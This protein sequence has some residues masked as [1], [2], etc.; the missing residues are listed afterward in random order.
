[1]TYQQA[2]QDKIGRAKLTIKEAIAGRQISCRLTYEAGELGIDDSGSL[3]VLFRIVSDVASLQAKNPRGKNF[4]QAS[5]SNHKVKI[6]LSTSSHAGVYEKIGVRPWTKGLVLNFGNHY[7]EKGDL[8]HIDF[9]NWRMQTF[10]EKT[11]EFRVMID[12]FATA[13]YLKLPNPPETKILPDKPQKLT[14]ITPTKIRVGERFKFL[15]KLEDQW[16]NPCTQK[17]GVFKLQTPAGLDCPSEVNFENGRAEVKVKLAQEGISFINAGWQKLNS[18]S[19]PLIGFKSIKNRYFWADLHGQ[20]E[21]T[22]GTNNVEDY[23]TFARNWAFLDIAGHQ[24]NDFQIINDFWQKLNQ[25]TKR[26]N[27]DGE[28]ITL[29]GYEWSGNTPKGGDRNVYYLEEGLPIHKSSHALINHFDDLDSDALSVQELFAKVP[30]KKTLIAAHVGGRFADLGIHDETLERN[31][32]IHSCWGTFEW[33][34]FEALKRGYRIGIVANSDGHTGRPGASHPTFAHFNSYGG[35]TC[36]LAPKLT[37]K[38]IF[39]ALYQ[40]HCYA[41][42][43][44]RIFLAVSCQTSSQEGILGDIFKNPQNPIFKVNCVG[45]NQI[46]RIE[47]YNLDKIIHTHYPPVKKTPGKTIKIIW[48]GSKVK[49]RNRTFSWKGSAKIINNQIKSLGKINFYNQR[50][51]A[52]RLQNQ[53]NWQGLTT[54]GLQGLILNL[55]QNQGEL[56]LEVNQKK[57]NLKIKNINQAPQIFKMGGLDAFL[58]I[59]QAS[60]HSQ[61][62]EINFEIPIKNLK[63]GENPIF[64][65]AIQKDGHLAWSSPIY[66]VKSPADQAGRH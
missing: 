24:A 34:L 19:N 10:C 52:R 13:K 27:K 48:S 42:T 3:K 41:T 23:F 36:V 6:N 26:F 29:P 62:Q 66:L 2:Y 63:K 57:L 47:I 4:V 12:P 17:S 14:I 1:M 60:H 31:I 50:N 15:V 30:K 64:V 9:K 18:Q 45:T 5:S 61:P 21:E 56:K 46:D 25:T 20:S 44:A 37:R 59:Y 32:E 55:T 7:L 51:F 16:G 58:S 39:Q 28:F 43:G 11:F 35:L 54:G 33:F 49:G 8:V 22:V 38:E 65:K 53:I 40:R